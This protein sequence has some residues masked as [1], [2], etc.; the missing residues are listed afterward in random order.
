VKRAH[1]GEVP[2]LR[3]FVREF[4]SPRAAGADGYLADKGLIPLPA[5]ELKA[6]QATVAKILGAEATRTAAA[7]R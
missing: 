4:V 6:Q 5:P 7:A 1:L 2:G 3:E